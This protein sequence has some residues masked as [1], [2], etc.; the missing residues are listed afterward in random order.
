M[1]KRL[2]KKLRRDE[3]Q[4]LGLAIAFTLR[5][6]AG[7]E[8]ALDIIDSLIAE[9]IDPQHL[10]LYAGGREVWTGFITL[11]GRGSVTEDHKRAVL[12]WLGAHPGITNVRSG[13]LVDAWYSREER[14]EVTADPD[15]SVAD[16]AAPTQNGVGL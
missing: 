4:E 8:A 9:A 6:A 11:F 12:D 2:R 5:A 16:Q 15:R 1:R 13:P 14:F 7:S 3:F 10:A